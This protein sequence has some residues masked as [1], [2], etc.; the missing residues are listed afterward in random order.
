MLEMNHISKQF[1]GV[2][3]LD[4][5]SLRAEP[6]RVLALIGVNGAGKSTLMNVLGGVIKHDEGEILINGKSVTIGSP[7]EA[8]LNGV[9]FIHQEPLFFASMTV[10]EN[11][12][13]S[14]FF[15]S[16][17]PG[18]V[19]SAKA[20]REAKKYL[21]ILGSN[22]INPKSKM[23]D[24]TIGARQMV[25]IARALAAGAPERK[26]QSVSGYR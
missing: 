11:V 18:V 24:I 1:P 20:N 6:G 8:E 14:N 21:E 10:A 16:S 23:E 5:V 15:K 13:I 9:A 12:Y 4:D 3:A 7:K 19:D 26:K 2:K 17:I 22:D 25:E